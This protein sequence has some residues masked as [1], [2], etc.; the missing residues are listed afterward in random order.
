METKIVTIEIGADEVTRYL[1]TINIEVPVSMEDEVLESL[2]PSFFDDLC[3]E[4][5]WE[6][7][8]TD[9][10][11]PSDNTVVTILPTDVS[12]VPSARLIEVA[13]QIEIRPVSSASRLE[14]Q[15]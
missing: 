6:V 13:G 10:R 1:R 3:E 4:F 9:G 11:Y 15:Q 14:T 5:D 2:S 7:E 12:E 8:E